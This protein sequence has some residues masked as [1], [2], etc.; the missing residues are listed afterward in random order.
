MG[1]VVRGGVGGGVGDAYVLTDELNF[2]LT[3]SMYNLC[4]DI[5]C[6]R[7]TLCWS[8]LEVKGERSSKREEGEEEE[9]EEKEE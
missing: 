9:E 4:V 1:W 6:L 5:W 8:M 2:I 7:F 3:F